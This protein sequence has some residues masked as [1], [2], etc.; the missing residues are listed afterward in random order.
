MTALQTEWLRI[1]TTALAR[2]NWLFVVSRT[3]AF[4]LK[5]QKIL[6]AAEAGRRLGVRYLLEGSIRRA[7]DRVRVTG[8]L[9][10]AT[11]GA[12]LWA[13]HFDGQLDNLFDLQ[14]EIVSSTVG[15]IE[16]TLL[17]AEAERA[18]SARPEKM[19]APTTIISGQRR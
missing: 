1:L 6:D 3:S 17:R 16:P 9:I 2:L 12:H 8:Q 15:A 4:A 11:S 5:G 10:E 14:D 18:R 7:G 19:F 13:D